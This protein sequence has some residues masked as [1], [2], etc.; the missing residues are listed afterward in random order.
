MLTKRQDTSHWIIP[1]IDCEVIIKRPG[2]DKHHF[3]EVVEAIWLDAGHIHPRQLAVDVTVWSGMRIG[4]VIHKYSY[5][6]VGQWRS[7]N[8]M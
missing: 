4:R 1:V 5:M 2:Q 6:L 7:K 3:G 8:K